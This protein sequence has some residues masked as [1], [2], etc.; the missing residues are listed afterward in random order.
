M[1]NSV[2]GYH[3][4]FIMPIAQHMPDINDVLDAF[5][6]EFFRRRDEGA[7][8]EQ[9][10]TILID[11]VGSLVSDVDKSDE[12]EVEVARKLKETARICGQEARG[13]NMGGI[14]ISQDAAGLSW[15]RKRALMILA[16]Q[17]TMWSERLLVCNNDA[18]IARAM[19]TWPKGRTLAYGIAFPEGPQVVQ[20]PLFTAHTVEATRY[21]PMPELPIKEQ[22]AFLPERPTP[23]HSV[24]ADETPP[25]VP[26]NIISMPFRVSETEQ[27]PEGKNRTA[28][29]SDETK[30]TILKLSQDGVPL[31]KI[32]GYVGLAG[33]KYGIFKAVCTE[34]GIRKAEEA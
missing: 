17:V 26:S 8:R 29:V 7:P 5:L 32:A 13:F 19:D 9:A 10:I 14:F 31:R 24:S 12:L 6:A 25:D 30:R 3:S 33:E 20:Q 11:E 18:K 28:T 23:K 22:R 4:R 2:K 16:H 34:L 1:T 15:L 27:I 21:P